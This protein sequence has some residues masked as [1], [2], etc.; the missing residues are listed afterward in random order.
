MHCIET[1]I[2]A[3]CYLRQA[4]YNINVTSVR[5]EAVKNNKIF[6]VLIFNTEYLI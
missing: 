6:Y 2:K 5:T 3:H 1:D 4:V